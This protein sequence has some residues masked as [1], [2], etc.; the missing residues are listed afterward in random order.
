LTPG[1]ISTVTTA[2]TQRATLLQE[3]NDELYDL[4]KIGETGKLK[5]EASRVVNRLE[6]SLHGTPS[7]LVS[8]LPLRSSYCSQSATW[9]LAIYREFFFLSP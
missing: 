7:L 5:E 1:T 3:E 8:A 9:S 4:L 2:L 6:G